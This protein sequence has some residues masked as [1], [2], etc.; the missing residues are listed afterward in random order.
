MQRL[1]LLI[2]RPHTDNRRPA[3]PH[4]GQGQADQRQGQAKVTKPTQDVRKPEPAADGELNAKTMP[5]AGTKRALMIE[6]LKRP[7]SAMVRPRN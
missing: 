7:D 3:R 5:R 4:T 6:L 2:S 1:H